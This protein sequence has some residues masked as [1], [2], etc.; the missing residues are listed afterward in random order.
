MR[1]KAELPGRGAQDLEPRAYTALKEREAA[2][3]AS[4]MRRLLYV[5]ATRARD[6]LV[7]TC[8]GK[9]RNKDGKPASVLLGPLADALPAPGASAGVRGT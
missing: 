1:L 9:L 8:F 2:M 3:A 7:V 6:Q 4:E 5:A